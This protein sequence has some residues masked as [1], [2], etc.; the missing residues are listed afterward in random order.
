MENKK[1]LT[2]DGSKGSNK[3]KYI[4]FSWSI[5]GAVCYQKPLASLLSGDDIMAVFDQGEFGQ[6]DQIDL[7]T[8]TFTET[9]MVDIKQK[10]RHYNWRCAYKPYNLD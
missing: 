10:R 1:D 9:T 8:H 7:S 3:N 6:W 4:G 5:G 2:V